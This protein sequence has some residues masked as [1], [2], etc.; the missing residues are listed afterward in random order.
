VGFKEEKRWKRKTQDA[1]KPKREGK[2]RL[3]VSRKCGR[4]R[5]GEGGR[6]DGHVPPGKNVYP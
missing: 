5:E 4:G 3:E 6:E 2:M 1:G